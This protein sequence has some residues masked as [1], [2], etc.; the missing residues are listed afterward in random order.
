MDETQTCVC[1][2][3]S[4]RVCVCL[5]VCVCYVID[6]AA[7]AV[8]RILTLAGGGHDPTHAKL[9]ALTQPSLQTI[10]MPWKN[11]PEDFTILQQMIQPSWVYY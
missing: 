5:C 6:K 3:V 2:C 8:R 11:E 4:V 9:L 7:F 10:H 1:V